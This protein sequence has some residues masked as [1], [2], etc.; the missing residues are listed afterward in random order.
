[1][2]NARLNQTEMIIIIWADVH[3][4]LIGYILL[5]KKKEIDKRK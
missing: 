2:M 3:L 4:S 5:G 1:M